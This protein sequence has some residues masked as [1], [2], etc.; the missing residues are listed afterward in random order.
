MSLRPLTNRAHLIFGF[1][2]ANTIKETPT[3]DV[4]GA[5]DVAVLPL[6]AMQSAYYYFFLMLVFFLGHPQVGSCRANG[7]GW[8]NLVEGGL[9]WLGTIWDGVGCFLLARCRL[10]WMRAVKGDLG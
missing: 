6:R 1:V 2:F 9:G 3:Q 5:H 4:P 10:R 8:F 7:L